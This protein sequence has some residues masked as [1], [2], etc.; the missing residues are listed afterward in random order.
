VIAAVAD[1]RAG[2]RLTLSA[3]S[4]PLIAARKNARSTIPDVVEDDACVRRRVQYA[5]R[6]TT[7]IPHRPALLITREPVEL[8]SIA[9]LCHR[10]RSHSSSRPPEPS[11]PPV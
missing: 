5:L 11:T 6:F 4:I 8:K 10:S 2:R 7:V 1:E 3:P 9:R